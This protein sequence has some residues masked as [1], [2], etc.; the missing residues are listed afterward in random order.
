MQQ[1]TITQPSQ[2][3][4][5]TLVVNQPGS[6]GRGETL[7][8]GLPPTG[9]DAQTMQNIMMQVWGRMYECLFTKCGFQL[10]LSPEILANP[11]ADKSAFD[12]N[13]KFSVLDGI[14]V[15]DIPGADKLIIACTA[16]DPTTMTTKKEAITNGQV[17]GFVSKNAGLPMFTVYLNVNGNELKR[18]F[19]PQNPWKQNSRGY[20][21]PALQAQ[22]GH[23]IAYIMDG[24][25]NVANKFR[26]KIVNGVF[27]A[28]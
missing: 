19:V 22:Q 21:A 5:S 15:A 18:L 12:A 27:S 10:P 28:T 9:L 3:V 17:K 6:T 20:S 23:K 16:L 7:R 8:T 24:A 13:A 26:G 2:Q 14:S 4:T 11:N 1:P 25:D